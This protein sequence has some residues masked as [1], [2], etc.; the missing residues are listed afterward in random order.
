M[1]WTMKLI[2]INF[3]LIDPW[4]FTIY[5]VRANLHKTVEKFNRIEFHLH[6]MFLAISPVGEVPMIDLFSTRP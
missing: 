5:I 2:E 6:A 1:I 4:N 3:I